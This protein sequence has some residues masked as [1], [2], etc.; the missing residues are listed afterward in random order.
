MTLQISICQTLL[1]I[2]VSSIIGLN[3]GS[4]TPVPEPAECRRP[5]D[6]Y[7]RVHV[8]GY[9]INRRT[10]AMLQY[11]AELYGGQI[12]V[13][14]KS[15]TQG[16]Y[17]D[18]VAASFGTHSGGGAVDISLVAPNRA[19]F[20]ILYDDIEPLL[21]ALRLAGFSAWYRK[22]GELGPG[23]PLHV[24]AVAI[25]DKELSAPAREQLDGPA[26]YF[27]GYN[28]LPVKKGGK[29]VSDAYGGPVICRWML[30]AGYGDMREQ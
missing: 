6:D 1:T 13:A 7:Q 10:L 2:I 26:G 19:H 27:K 20:T 14:A 5:P 18:D 22:V 28:G 17:N 16:S 12:D 21:R 8:N 30:D 29:P 3:S 24:H 25:G 11:A 4:P 9:T 15:I 23:S